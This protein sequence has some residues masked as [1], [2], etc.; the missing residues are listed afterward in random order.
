MKKLNK[1]SGTAIMLFLV[2]ALPH[3]EDG[4]LKQFGI[5]FGALV[6]AVCLVIVEIKSLGAGKKRGYVLRG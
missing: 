6:V 4:G 3:Y 1:I 5:A 2:I